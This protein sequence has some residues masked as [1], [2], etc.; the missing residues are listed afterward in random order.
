M[1][2]PHV[3]AHLASSPPVTIDLQR[4]VLVSGLA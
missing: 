4:D 1:A 3:T 2:A